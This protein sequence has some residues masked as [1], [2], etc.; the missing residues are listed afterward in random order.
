M[1]RHSHLRAQLEARLVAILDRVVRIEGDLRRPADRDWSER[2]T[3]MENDEV[4]EGLD[5]LGRAEV[6]SIR[7]TL[8]RMDTGDYGFCE[9]CRQPIEEK[10]LLAVPTASTCLACT[11]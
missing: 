5:E 4:L 9:Q 11:P 10:R 2:A 8:R 3:E 6:R 7:A 1:T